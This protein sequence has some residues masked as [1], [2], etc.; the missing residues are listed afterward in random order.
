MQILILQNSINTVGQCFYF[1]LQLECKHILTSFIF[2]LLTV[3][4][5]RTTFIS[6]KQGISLKLHLPLLSS[7]IEHHYHKCI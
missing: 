1:D 6:W 2:P 4:F 7:L 5:F 3:Y